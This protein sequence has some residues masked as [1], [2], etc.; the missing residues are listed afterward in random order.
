MS[1]DFK[2]YH[3]VRGKLNNSN[4]DLM[5]VSKNRT[6]EDIESL[7][8]KNHFLFGENRVQE[9]KSK[10]SS[11]RFKYNFDL[12]LIGPLQSNKTEE[13]LQLFDCIQTL[14]RKKII[15]QII[16]IENKKKINLRTKSFF[17]QIN[18]GQEK[19]KSGIDINEISKVYKYCTDRNLSIKGIM[20]IPPNKLD[21]SKFFKDMVL[22]KN[23][24]NPKLNLSMGMSNDYELALKFN[25]NILRIGSLFFYD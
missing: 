6:I 15:D 11:L 18:I 24:L 25:S 2:N 22:I 12:H 17:L 7:L 9:A 21:A 23:Q 19:Q 8:K 1:V 10:F 3:S 4:C 13:A 16:T 20:C 5:V 14:D